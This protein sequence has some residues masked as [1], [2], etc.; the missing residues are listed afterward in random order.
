M[1]KFYVVGKV[2]LRS[3]EIEYVYNIIND[4]P[5]S[6]ISLDYSFTNFVAK[7]FDKLSD[8]RAFKNKVNDAGDIVNCDYCVF[9]IK[10]GFKL[11]AYQ[12]IAKEV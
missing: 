2:N 11:G 3:K 7:K 5:V 12:F 4:K 6:T 10:R 9:L 1:E 8:A